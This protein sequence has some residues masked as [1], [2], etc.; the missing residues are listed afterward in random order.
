MPDIVISTE[1]LGKSYR[2]GHQVSHGER[3]P[4]LRDALARNARGFARRTRDLFSGRTLVQGDEVEEFWA[5]KDVSFEIKR[6]DRVGIIGRNG[7]GKST[8]LK[9]LSRI[10]EP[11]KGRVRITGRVASLLE[12]GTGFHPELTGRENIYLNGAIL[13]MRREEIRRKFDAIVDFSEVGKFLDTPVKHYSSGMYVRLAFAVAA[14][15]ESEIL[16][17]D[18]VLAVGDIAFQKKCLV[19]L[20]ST[21]QQG[22]TVLLV[23][24][25]LAAI[26]SLCNT[27]MLFQEGRLVMADQPDTVI[28]RYLENTR[29]L[30]AT[31]L[32]QRQDRSGSG[33]VRIASVVASSDSGRPGLQSGKPLCITCF[34]EFRSVPPPLGLS[35]A[36]G[37]DDSAGNRIALL[38]SE[39]T[40]PVPLPVTTRT[41]CVDVTMDKLQLAQGHYRLTLFCSSGGEVLDWIKDAATIEVEN[42]DYYGTGKLPQGN[43]G[44]LLLNYRFNCTDRID[45][46]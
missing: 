20:E 11:T 38:N 31:P 45:L 23:S 40:G 36:I 6:G 9:I 21:S 2:V 14:H 46:L 44:P 29:E 5:L 13:G 18:E 25:S 19:M 10:T 1:N 27:A 3:H 15:L 17:A 34:L 26:R 28:D 41:H 4:A 8:L 32:S 35:L 30:T 7:A 12:V 37:I 24:H 16:I 42:S 43:Q 39:I 33:A 22:R